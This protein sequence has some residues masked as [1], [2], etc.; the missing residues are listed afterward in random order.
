MI[1]FKSSFALR[2]QELPDPIA[3]AGVE[4]VNHPSVANFAK[5]VPNSPVVTADPTTYASTALRTL[6]IGF[7]CL[8]RCVLRDRRLAMFKRP[9]SLYLNR[10]YTFDSVFDLWGNHSFFFHGFHQFH[11]SKLL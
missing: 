6:I 5:F 3:V 11:L 10:L 2:V 4:V 7:G 1:D 8:R 9:N